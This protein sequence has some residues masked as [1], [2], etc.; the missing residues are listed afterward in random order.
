MWVRLKRRFR[1]AIWYKSSMRRG[2]RAETADSSARPIELVMTQKSDPHRSYAFAPDL[3]R[4]LALY[5][6]RVIDR[7]AIEA[8]PTRL[9][10]TLAGK[11]RAAARRSA[12]GRRSVA[13]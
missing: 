11:R 6:A 3:G 4:A 8:H 7:A 13:G 5:W 9:E 10:A 12:G 2:F 1:C